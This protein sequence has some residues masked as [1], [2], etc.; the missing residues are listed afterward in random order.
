MRKWEDGE[1]EIWEEDKM[2]GGR[3]KE[4]TEGEEEITGKG[5]LRS[6][7]GEYGEREGVFNLAACIHQS[8]P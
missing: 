5:E 8:I 1:K 7:K 4:R 3:D 6:R 2:K